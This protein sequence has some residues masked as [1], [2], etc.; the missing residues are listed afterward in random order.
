MPLRKEVRLALGDIS[1]FLDALLAWVLDKADSELTKISVLH[2]LSSIVN[3]RSNGK[4]KFVH[5]FVN[6][7]LIIC[8]ELSS[9]LIDKLENFWSKEIQNGTLPVERR[10]WAIK[11]WTWVLFG[12]KTMSCL[13]L[14]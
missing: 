12:L 10:I 6:L 13:V 11:S 4:W 2:M 1:K 8:P 5:R 9:F 3:R 14:T 7:S